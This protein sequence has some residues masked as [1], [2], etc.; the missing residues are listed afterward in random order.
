MKQKDESVA[1]LTRGVEFLFRK[2]KVQ[3]IKG[4]A[5]LQGEGRV[6]VALADGGHAQLEARDI[7]IA[8][9]SEPAPLPGVPVDNQR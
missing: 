8:T 1:A 9:G 7:V 4:W 2:H 3:W 6:G 5:R